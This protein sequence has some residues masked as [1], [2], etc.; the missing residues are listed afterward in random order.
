MIQIAE[1]VVHPFSLVFAFYGVGVLYLRKGRLQEA[2]ATRERA[3]KHFLDHR[4]RSHDRTPSPERKCLTLC[5]E[6]RPCDHRSEDQAKEAER[7]MRG[8]ERRAAGLAKPLPK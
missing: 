2:I 6:A 5:E 3:L 1:A 4:S 8:R 7:A